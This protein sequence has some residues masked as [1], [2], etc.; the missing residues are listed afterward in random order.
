MSNEL[1]RIKGVAKEVGAEPVD[2]YSAPK[3]V[4][5]AMYTQEAVRF[6]R[7]LQMYDE[8]IQWADALMF[9]GQMKRSYRSNVLQE[10]R[11]ML[12]RFARQIH[13][14]Y[15]QS[16]NAVRREKQARQ[17]A[18]RAKEMA[19]SSHGRDGE[20]VSEAKTA[21][22]SPDAEAT[23]DSSSGKDDAAK[24]VKKAAKKATKKTAAKKTAAKTASTVDSEEA[25]A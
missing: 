16:R 17:K 11:N 15:M 12:V 2:G 22:T 14:L 10:S 23:I 13:V 6:A 3:T 9:A 18:R 4:T 8:L 21:K 20:T 19:A 25:K 7:L 24:P 1:D 5:V